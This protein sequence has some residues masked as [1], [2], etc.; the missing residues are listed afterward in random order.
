MKY[1]L[2]IILV[3]IATSSLSSTCENTIIPYIV[4]KTANPEVV[5]YLSSLKTTVL[6]S[7]EKVEGSFCFEMN[8]Y[9]EHMR[10]KQISSRGIAVFIIVLGAMIPLIN[11]IT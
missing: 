10:K 4:S 9:K 8:W 5:S 1:L 2:T 3:L 11:F 6:F 7:N